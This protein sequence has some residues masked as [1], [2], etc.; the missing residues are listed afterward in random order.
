MIRV[1]KN[2]NEEKKERNRDSNIYINIRITKKTH[3]L[4]CLFGKK[5]ET[6]DEVI[7]KLIGIKKSIKNNI[8]TKD[9]FKEIL[10]NSKHGDSFVFDEVVK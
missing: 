7:K 9:N 1:I 10:E 5:N 3:D 6:F 4:L 2:K 8:L